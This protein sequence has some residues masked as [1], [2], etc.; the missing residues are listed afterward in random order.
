M[1]GAGEKVK[2]LV[3]YLLAAFKNLVDKTDGGG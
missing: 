1:F 3:F 2:N